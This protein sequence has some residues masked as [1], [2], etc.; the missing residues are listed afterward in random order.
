M[1]LS[2]P[3]LALLLLELQ[4]LVGR[5]ATKVWTPSTTAV[6]LRMRG[7]D[8]KDDL[9]LEVA[10]PRA[11]LGVVRERPRGEASAWQ[12]Q[13]RG[14]IEGCALERIWQ[15]IP[16]D[17]IVSLDFRH[18]GGGSRLMVELLGSRGQILLLDGE[19]RVVAAGSSARLQARG[20]RLDAAYQAPAPKPDRVKGASA[21]LPAAAAAAAGP[22]GPD[23][24]GT[25]A[26]AFPISVALEAHFT[27]LD[28]ESG[29]Q[30]ERRT[31]RRSLTRARKKQAR[32]CEAL[33]KSVARAAE[34]PRLQ[35]FGELLKQALGQM[36]RGLTTIEVRD[37]YD[38]EGGKIT[39]DLDPKL[40]P[41]EN[42]ESYFKRARKLQRGAEV[43]RERLAPAQA[44]RTHLLALLEEADQ[45]DALED[46]EA[47]WKKARK[48]GVRRPAPPVSRDGKAGKGKK[49]PEQRKPY[50]TFEASNGDRILVGRS[51]R[52]NHALTFQVARGRD[53]WLHVRDYPGSHVV[54]RALK[55]GPV[56]AG[57]LVEA[58]LLAAHF[59][60][61]REAG[62]VEVSW[63]E[64]KHLRHPPGSAPG[65]VSLAK[66]RSL[67]VIPDSGRLQALFG[68]E[69]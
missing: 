36:R 57:T 56:D 44:A 59:S 64:R 63:T 34:A 55:D 3:E 26:A 37:W 7:P 2:S 38:P 31:L 41:Q 43:A 53:L 27:P 25:P 33:E 19:D 20:L 39:V 11:R 12:A 22:G 30:E 16:G 67:R 21:A 1:S 24:P 10:H 60:E 47:I 68:R 66:A 32:T 54:I 61:G 69:E 58:G 48:V 17:R 62:P 8:G 18:K 65:L 28:R 15:P 23:S 40:G 49:A 42:L 35:R 29:L 5:R 6:V 45:V 46:F 50:R 4:A 51:A 9:L 14:E 52:D 13:L